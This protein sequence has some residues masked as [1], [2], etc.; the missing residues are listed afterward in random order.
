MS[1]SV[2]IADDHAVVRSGLNS[3][4]MNTDIEVV[5]EAA[6]AEEALAAIVERQPRGR[7]APRAAPWGRGRRPA[8][9]RATGSIHS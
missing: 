7:S 5:G 9:R 1:V 4:L 6:D 3:L 8:G 2:V